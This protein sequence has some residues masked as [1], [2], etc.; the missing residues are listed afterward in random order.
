MTTVAHGSC[1]RYRN[2]HPLGSDCILQ[3]TDDLGSGAW[4]DFGGVVEQDGCA[5][6]VRR[7]VWRG[8][9]P[10]F[11][12]TRPISFSILMQNCALLLAS[13]VCSTHADSSPASQRDRKHN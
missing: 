6:E 10:W 8:V 12:N 5:R 13:R 2:R 3:A 11:P 4:G 9:F 1:G 7:D